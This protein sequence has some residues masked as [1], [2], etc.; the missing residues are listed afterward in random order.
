MS[1]IDSL[2]TDRTAADAQRV[3]EIAAKMQRNTATAE[4][5]A[6]YVSASMKGAYNAA[7]LNRV[8]E[9]CEYLAARFWQYGYPVSVRRPDLGG[10]DFW[11][12]GDIPTTAQL[13]V[14]L[15]NIR[16]LRSVLKQ[17]EKTPKVPADMESLTVEDANDLERILVAVNRLLLLL[18][19]AFRQSG[20][21]TAWSGVLPLPVYVPEIVE[22]LLGL[23]TAD[24]RAVYTADGLAVCLRS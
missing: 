10:R 6:A 22:I 7:D 15:D 18:A 14:Y 4:E 24:G 11:I 17:A 5:V 21:F 19:A 16:R 8:T 12:V 23:Y 1:I 9:A 13:S 20:Q 3:A 2:I